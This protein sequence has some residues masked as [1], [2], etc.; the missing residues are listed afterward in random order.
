M[1]LIQLT[2]VLTSVGLSQSTRTSSS[3]QFS[4]GGVELNHLAV[5]DSTGQVY[6]G[7]VNW[8]YQLNGDLEEVNSVK[9][10]P[11]LDSPFCFYP[12]TNSTTCFYKGIKSVQKEL[13]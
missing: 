3:A 13:T 10:G 4:R 8:L 2:I 1:F 12:F 9:T 6:V 11:V 7:A 5:D